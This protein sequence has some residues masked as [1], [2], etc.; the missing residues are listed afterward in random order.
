MKVT[1][2]SDENP[3]VGIEANE[4]VR[5]DRLEQHIRTLTVARDWLKR[6]LDRRKVSPK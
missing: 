4:F 6:E 1:L 3:D 2:R 5:L